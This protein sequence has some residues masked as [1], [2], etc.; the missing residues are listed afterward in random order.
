MN[1]CSFPNF[2]KMKLL[3]RE[4]T[5]KLARGEGFFAAAETESYQP[6]GSVLGQLTPDSCVAACC[7]MLLRDYAGDVAESFLRDAL[8]TDEGGASLS[9]APSVLRNFGLTFFYTYFSGLTLDQL[10]TATRRAPAI[11]VVKASMSGGLHSVMVDGV[12]NDSAYIRD[13]MPLGK[14]SAYKVS[15][16]TFTR[17]WAT[18]NGLGRGVIVVE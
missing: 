16:T 2:L 11:V 14:G 18:E 4:K 1:V 10:F 12:D 7:R 17:H 9:K 8:D 15:I 3:R 5:P 6:S 13:P